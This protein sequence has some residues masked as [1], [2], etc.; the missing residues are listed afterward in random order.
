M[1]TITELRTRL[2]KIED[3]IDAAISNGIE[4]QI[5]GSHSVKNQSLAYLEKQRSR[6]RKQIARKLGYTSS[7]S[8]TDFS[9]GYAGGIPE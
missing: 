5:V 4:Y 6:V 8:Q 9:G 7:R 1:S 3:A 2:D